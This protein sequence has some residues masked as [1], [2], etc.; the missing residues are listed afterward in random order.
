MK[1]TQAGRWVLLGN[2]SFVRSRA[3]QFKGSPWVMGCVSWGALGC[4]VNNKD[5]HRL[6]A[7]ESY[8]ISYSAVSPGI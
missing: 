5:I 4:Q 1:E 6:I 3:V 2:W 8:C 7:L